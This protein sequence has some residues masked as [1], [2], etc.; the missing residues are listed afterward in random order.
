M[1]QLH[2]S[3]LKQAEEHQA[4]P[5]AEALKSARAGDTVAGYWG[6]SSASERHRRS[7]RCSS[8]QQQARTSARCDTERTDHHRPPSFGAV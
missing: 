2:P 4:G 8:D 6:I 5:A 7:F 1:A 3:S